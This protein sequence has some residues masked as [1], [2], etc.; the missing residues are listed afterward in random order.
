MYALL[1][2]ALTFAPILAP[3]MVLGTAVAL[4]VRV[5]RRQPVLVRHLPS[6]TTCALTAVLATGPGGRVAP[7]PREPNTPTRPDGD[8]TFDWEMVLAVRRQIDQPDPRWL[9]RLSQITAETLVVAG[10]PRSHVPQ[11]G[12]AELARCIPVG[13][14][15]TIPVGHLIHHAA[16]EAF[17]KVVAAFLLTEENTHPARQP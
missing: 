16:P 15:V 12:V 5:R 1:F 4:A 9:E 13:H 10:G 2:L 14:M 17:T 11:D 3:C 7:R 6:V 8:L